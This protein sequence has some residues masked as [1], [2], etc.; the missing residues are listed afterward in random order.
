MLFCSGREPEPHANFFSPNRLRK[1][2]NRRALT[3]MS[4]NQSL[5]R[6]LLHDDRAIEHT[7]VRARKQQKTT[8]RELVYYGSFPSDLVRSRGGVGTFKQGF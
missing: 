5:V 7:G 6:N 8:E 3:L 1:N 2:D 4:A